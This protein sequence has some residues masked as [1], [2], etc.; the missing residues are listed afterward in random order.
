VIDGATCNA[1]IK[2]G[3][4]GT[5]PTFPVGGLP[6]GPAVNEATGTVYVP[7]FADNNMSVFGFGCPNKSTRAHSPSNPLVEPVVVT[8]P[9]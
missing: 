5:P 1:T 9:L 3:C 8:R 7:N 6:I 4:A 2:A